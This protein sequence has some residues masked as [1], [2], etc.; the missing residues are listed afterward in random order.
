M[1]PVHLRDLGSPRVQPDDRPRLSRTREKIHI[2]AQQRPQTRVLVM[3]G[4]SSSSQPIT[5]IPAPMEHRKADIKAIS[6][7]GRD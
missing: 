1:S 7:L 3:N 2:S 4:S 5:D 6:P